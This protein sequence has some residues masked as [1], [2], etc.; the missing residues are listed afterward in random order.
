MLWAHFRFKRKRKNN[1]LV[2]NSFSAKSVCPENF[3]KL[4]SDA[5]YCYYLSES[6]ANWL[7][8]KSD[9]EDRNARLAEL[10]IEDEYT[11]VTTQYFDGEFASLTPVNN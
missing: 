4:R 10:D 6:T 9:C 7:T 2:T 8:A 11:D 5:K 1:A 3:I